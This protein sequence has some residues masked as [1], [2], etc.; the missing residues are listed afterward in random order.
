MSVMKEV[1]ALKIGNSGLN[2]FLNIRAV[3]VSDT[4]ITV[5]IKV[6]IQG[7]DLLSD[8][9]LEYVKNG[10]TEKEMINAYKMFLSVKVILISYS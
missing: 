4:A 6:K 3:K 7:P 9:Y 2:Q 8:K 1:I 10:K 5:E